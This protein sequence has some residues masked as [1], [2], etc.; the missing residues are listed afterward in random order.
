VEKTDIRFPKKEWSVAVRINHWC[1]VSFIMMLTITGIYIAKPFTYLSGE[2][3]YKFLMGNTRFVHILFGVGL[4]FIFI[5]RVYLMFFSRFHADWKDFFAFT[6]IKNTIAQ[7]K[8]YLLVSNKPAEHK[9]LYGPLQSL[10]YGG[11]MVMLF[12]MCLTGIIL[13]GPAHSAGLTGFIYKLVK[14]LE[15][16][17]GGLAVVRVVHH[18]L[19]WGFIL[20]GFV[21]LYM[22]FW[23][24]CVFQE[25]TVS[26]MIAGLLFKK[27]K[28]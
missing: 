15:N 13:M 23:Y 22:A 16:I 27:K 25:G 20:F 6:D 8:F 19:T 5:W 1:M 3:Y 21:H 9:Y 24:D 26:S 14:P 11:L 2:T 12:A 7:I 4:V 18:I 17:M 10:A 28:H